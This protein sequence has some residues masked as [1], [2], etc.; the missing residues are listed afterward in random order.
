MAEELDDLLDELSMSRQSG[1]LED[2]SPNDDVEINDKPRVSRQ[3]TVVEKKLMDT[4]NRVRDKPTSIIKLLDS[5]I[6]HFKGKMYSV[7]EGN[8]VYNTETQEGA[9]AIK[10]AIN[11]LEKQ[12]PVFPLKWAE[13]LNMASE[14]IRSNLG[15]SGKTQLEGGDKL[16]SVILKYGTYEGSLNQLVCF[17]DQDADEIVATWIVG[18]GD[19]ARTARTNI[20]NKKFKFAGAALGSH[21]SDFKYCGVVHFVAGTWKDK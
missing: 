5:K 14:E 12:I 16:N 7:K 15:D 6:K 17:G 9:A 1:V 20:F 10:E 11:F 2:V 3:S 18:D 19:S 21:Q 4:I 13:G 8:T